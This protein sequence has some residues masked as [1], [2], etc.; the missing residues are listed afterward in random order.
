MTRAFGCHLDG[1]PNI[2]HILGGPNDRRRVHATPV[3]AGGRRDGAGRRGRCGTGA[4]RSLRM[5]ASSASC[6]ILTAGYGSDG[7]Y[8]PRGWTVN[9]IPSTPGRWPR[10]HAGV[11][12]DGERGREEAAARAP[13]RAPTSAAPSRTS[14][15]QAPPRRASSSSV[16]SDDGGGGPGNG[17][18]IWMPPGW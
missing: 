1:K 2:R 14:H 9:E 17:Q 6:F 3:L 7:C 5:I 13:R 10:P 16:A 8:V 11:P 18:G 15:V 12:G 4:L